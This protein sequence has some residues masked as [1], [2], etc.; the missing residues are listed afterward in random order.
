[1]TKTHHILRNDNDLSTN[2]LL[3]CSSTYI[4]TGPSA[5]MRRLGRRIKNDSGTKL[6]FFSL[7]I[8]CWKAPA[9]DYTGKTV[10]VHRF[11][12]FVFS[13]RIVLPPY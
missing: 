11:R 1:M 3:L 6:P 9:A 8:S 7:Q 13:S 10:Q 12:G 5:G 2:C 4:S